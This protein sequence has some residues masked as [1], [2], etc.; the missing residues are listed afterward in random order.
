MPGPYGPGRSGE[1][2]EPVRY[3]VVTAP[4]GSTSGRRGAAGTVM[5]PALEGGAPPHGPPSGGNARRTPRLRRGHGPGVDG[6]HGLGPAG[7]LS[8]RGGPESRLP[9]AA[10]PGPSSP[11][12]GTR[13]RSTT[14]ISRPRGGPGGRR[15]PLDRRPA[16]GTGARRRLPGHAGGLRPPPGRRPAGPPLRGRPSRRRSPCQGGPPGE[17]A[18]A[19]AGRRGGVPVGPCRRAARPRRDRPHR[20]RVGGRR[21]VGSAPPAPASGRRR[22]PSSRPDG[23]R[24]RSPFPS[25]PPPSRTGTAGAGR[26]RPGSGRRVRDAER[27]RRVRRRR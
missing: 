5:V 24:T 25:S 27:G 13:R 15:P 18:G 20:P 12:C 8:H 23:R 17:A 14:A 9:P 19:G 22:S 10:G 1:G 21:P 16:A 6:Q 4:A 3:V 2:N 7:D 26:W 11:P